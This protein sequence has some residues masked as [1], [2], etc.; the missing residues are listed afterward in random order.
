MG[1]ILVAE[2]LLTNNYNLFMY[3]LLVCIQIRSVSRTRVS[4]LEG[5][6]LGCTI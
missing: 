4:Y 3:S 2:G 1:R 5:V 6:L